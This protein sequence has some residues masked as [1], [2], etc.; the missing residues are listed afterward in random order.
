MI[1]SHLDLQPTIK[2]EKES[3]YGDRCVSMGVSYNYYLYAPK[4][5]RLWQIKKGKTICI[6]KQSDG[7]KS[8]LKYL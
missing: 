5:Q 7:Y 3:A 4:T 6:G 1:H 2:D 8:L